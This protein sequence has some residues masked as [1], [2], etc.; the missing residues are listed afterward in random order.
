M[1]VAPLS[2][3]TS[4]RDYLKRIRF[5]YTQSVS[6]KLCISHQNLRYDKYIR[7]CD[8]IHVYPGNIGNSESLRSNREFSP[9]SLSLFLSPFSLLFHESKFLHDYTDWHYV[10]VCAPCPLLGHRIIDPP[11]KCNCKPTENIL[12]SEL[13]LGF[14]GENK[15]AAIRTSA[16]RILASTESHHANRVA[17]LA[18]DNV[19][20]D[21]FILL[22]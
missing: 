20:N 15:L 16:S 3:V 8:D 11:D 14:A 17:P 13:T 6:V 10:H 1:N 21:Q 22:Y 5:K 18:L 12:D 19:T 9:L 2:R 7:N 4:Q